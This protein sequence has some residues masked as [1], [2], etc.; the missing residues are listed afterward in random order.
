MITTAKYNAMGA[1][2]GYS[3]LIHLVG[4]ITPF[5]P[6]PSY[7]TSLLNVFYAGLLLLKDNILI[8][9]IQRKLQQCP[10]DNEVLQ[11]VFD[12][13]MQYKEKF[14]EQIWQILQ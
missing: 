13:F 2:V 10:Q 7:S 8:L 6:S 9:Q 1:G 11:Q 5:T 12:D 14:V 3:P 4:G